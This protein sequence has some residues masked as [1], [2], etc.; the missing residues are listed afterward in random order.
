[1]DFRAA[2]KCPIIAEVPRRMFDATDIRWEHHSQCLTGEI[3]GR[4]FVRP[5][6][7][8][9]RIGRNDIRTGHGKQP[10]INRALRYRRQNKPG[11][12]AFTVIPFALKWS[13]AAEIADRQNLGRANL[14]AERPT[15]GDGGD[16]CYAPIITV[17]LRLP[18]AWKGHSAG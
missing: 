12:I 15:R 1:M 13:A 16:D 14:I 10:A 6:N 17:R 2:S 4:G 3:A 9:D 7:A 11:E 8:R 5:L 18:E